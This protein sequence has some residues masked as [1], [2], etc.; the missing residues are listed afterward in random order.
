[1]ML[2]DSGGQRRRHAPNAAM[3]RETVP[4]PTT[5]VAPLSPRSTIMKLLLVMVAASLVSAALL[6][7]TVAQAGFA[8]HIA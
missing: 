5:R 8:V 3:R 2:V 4:H 7:P 1:M 6:I